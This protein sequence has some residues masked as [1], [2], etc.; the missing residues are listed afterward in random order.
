MSTALTNAKIEAN[1]IADH[2]DANRKTVGDMSLMPGFCPGLHEAP[3]DFAALYGM[4]KQQRAEAEAEA[5]GGR[6]R[7]DPP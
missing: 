3:D 6:A 5:P 1:A 7:E 2:I 4:R